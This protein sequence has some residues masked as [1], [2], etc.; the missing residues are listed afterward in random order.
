MYDFADWPNILRVFISEDCASLKTEKLALLSA[1]ID[2]MT[3]EAVSVAQDALFMAGA[4]DVTVTPALMKK[5]RPAVIVSAL[6][7]PGK[8]PAVEMAFFVN[9]S[10][11]GVRHTTVNRA[12]LPRKIKK[13]KTEFGVV[14]VKVAFLP[15]GTERDSPEF[16]SVKKIALHKKVPFDV[17]YRSALEKRV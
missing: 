2:D 14:D 9:T 4:L 8:V 3:P 15:D 5:G 12:S 11:L 10:T 6:C 16:E 13:V 7:H 17:V 1:N